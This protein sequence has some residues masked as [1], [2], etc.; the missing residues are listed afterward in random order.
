MT[1]HTGTLDE[2]IDDVRQNREEHARAQRRIE[3]AACAVRETA[4]LDAKRAIVLE[5]TGKY[6][7]Y[8]DMGWKPYA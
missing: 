2:L 3:A 8:K 5:Q 6:L 1:L 7:T 4:L